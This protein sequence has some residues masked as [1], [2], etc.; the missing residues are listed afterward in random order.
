MLKQAKVPRGNSGRKPGNSTWKPK[1]HN[2]TAFKTTVSL[3]L[4]KDVVE[5]ARK[6]HLNISRICEEALSSIIDVLEAQTPKNAQK[7]QIINKSENPIL[8]DEVPLLDE[9]PGPVA[10][11]GQSTGLL[12][13]GSWVQF[14]PGPPP[15]NN[16]KFCGFISCLLS[17]ISMISLWHF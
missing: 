3:Y 5:K 4:S 10:Q 2:K 15:P 11:P 7:Q 1:H 13:R 8:L 9:E 12:T 17:T 14:P 6:H 16:S